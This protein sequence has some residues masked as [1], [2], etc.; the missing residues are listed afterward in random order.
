MTITTAGAVSAKLSSTAAAPAKPNTAA[1][2]N[3]ANK[4]EMDQTAFLKL[5]TTQ[6]QNQNPLEPVK[7]E[8]FVA[9]LAQFSQLEATTKM[10]DSLATMA[11]AMK[12]DKLM[13]GASLIGKKVASPT[14]TAELVD[15]ANVR[16]TL[17]LE[18]GAS[19]VNLD[20]FDVNG[21][22][23]FSQSLGRQAP[24]EI[25]VTWPGYN[26]KGERM[27]PGRYNVVATVDAFGTVTKVPISTPSAVRS[28][29]F[30]AANNELM[31]ELTDG[32]SVGLSKVQRIDN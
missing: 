3:K 29:S 18:K 7:N 17:A 16:G 26:S 9:Q 31:L 24:G 32:S 25:D 15:G 19:A 11:A 22:K 20:V 5:F 4:G 30:N 2:P 27:P 12:S 6:L 10:A 14:G 8:A 21:S 1:T 13:T 28:V 23:V